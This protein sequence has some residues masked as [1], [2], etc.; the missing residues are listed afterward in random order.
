VVELS[1]LA[2]DPT[3]ADLTELRDDVDA[4]LGDGEQT[5]GVMDKS[6]A[7]APDPESDQ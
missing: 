4:R 7:G 1:H 6:I 3:L 2:A 5:V